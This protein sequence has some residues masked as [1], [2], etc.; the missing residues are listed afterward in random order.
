LEKEGKGDSVDADRVYF[1]EL[2]DR[3]YCGEELTNEELD[4]LDQFDEDEERRE[5][6]QSLVN[7]QYQAEIPAIEKDT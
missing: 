2:V 7:T 6:K 3:N 4:D 5:T 1:L